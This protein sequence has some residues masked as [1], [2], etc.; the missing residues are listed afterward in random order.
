MLGRSAR[1]AAL[2]LVLL[3][4]TA[5]TGMTARA[6]V[7]EVR[8]AL[9]YGFGFLPMMV[10]QHR[11]LVE[12]QLAAEQLPNVQVT[13][14]SLGGGAV[15]NDAVLSGNLDIATSGITPF[16]TLW[17]KTRG[18]TAVRAIGSL[19]TLP[20]WLNTSNPKIHGLE[21]IG[22]ADRIAVTAV[23]ISVHAILL[24]MAAAQRWGSDD[25]TRLDRYTVTL[26]QPDGMLAL[27][28]KSGEVDAHFT[29]PPFQYRELASPGIHR[30]IT[31]D[32]ILGGPATFVVAWTTE[33]FR[34][35]NPLVYKAVAGALQEALDIINT[36]QAAAAASYRAY[37]GSD[38]TNGEIA[39]MLSAPGTSFAMTPQNVMKYV[40]FMHRIGM[41]K[42]KPGSWTDLFFPELHTRPGS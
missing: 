39:D 30:I 33:A 25:Y 15:M 40:E 9:Q 29:A 13:W 42:V 28:S 37:A 21:D 5:A 19:G 23:K 36:D 1:L 17:A 12:R 11:K 38:E 27:L 2:G 24:Q 8:I 7:A 35:A 20:L 3:A 31:S 34:K 32:E 10:M 16:I 41:V 18:A 4:G 22:E 14:A 6:E 26:S